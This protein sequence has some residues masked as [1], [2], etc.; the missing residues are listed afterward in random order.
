MAKRQLVVAAESWI[1]EFRS[2]QLSV[3]S[4]LTE[5]CTGGCDK[6]A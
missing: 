3:D 5:F 1:K 2:W 4:E 6:R